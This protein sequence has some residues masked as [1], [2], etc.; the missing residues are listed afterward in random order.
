MLLGKYKLESFKYLL[1]K[2]RPKCSACG[3]E[4]EICVIAVSSC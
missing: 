4:A 2:G 3:M 1:L